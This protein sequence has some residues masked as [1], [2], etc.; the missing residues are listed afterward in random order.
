[1]RGLLGASTLLLSPRCV[2][3]SLFVTWYQSRLGL[4]LGLNL[5]PVVI[6][7]RPPSRQSSTAVAARPRVAVTASSFAAIAARL[8]PPS[9]LRALIPAAVKV[10]CLAT[11]TTTP[12][13]FV[14]TIRSQVN[15][16]AA[17]CHGFFFKSESDSCCGL[18]LLQRSALGC[19]L[20]VLQLQ[21]HLLVR[22]LLWSSPSRW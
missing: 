4:G 14:S 15:L 13:L 16:A 11:V 7:F 19:C 12:A 2:V 9:R 5:P 22:S 6:F 18:P 21:Q 17:V 3:G 1:M 20:L 10:A 8:Q